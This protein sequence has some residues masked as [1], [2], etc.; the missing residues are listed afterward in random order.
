MTP[1]A[2]PLQQFDPD[3]YIEIDDPFTGHRKL[4]RVDETGFAY[5]DLFGASATAFPIYQRLQPREVGNILGWGLH[6]VD[7]HPDDFPAWRTLVDR[8]VQSGHDPLTY[9]RAAHWAFSNRVYD[10]DQALAAGIAATERV[11][12]GRRRMDAILASA[13]AAN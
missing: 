6:V 12:V 13:G 4:A 9:N 8:L 2:L 7:H 11:Q 1:N 3:V 5:F 10:Y